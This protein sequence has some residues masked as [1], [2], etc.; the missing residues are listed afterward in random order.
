MKFY[1]YTVLGFEL[2]FSIFVPAWAQPTLKEFEP[3]EYITEQGWGYLSIS[4]KNGNGQDF[5]L[6]A[7]GANAHSC[8]LEGVIRD[9]KAVFSNDSC[10]ILFTKKNDAIQ[11]AVD[12][13]FFD[14]CRGFCGMRAG[15][16][17]SY[18]KPANGCDSQ[19]LADMQKQVMQ[20]REQSDFTHAEQV[21]S[22]VLKNCQKTLSQYRND[23]IHLQ[24]AEIQFLQGKKQACLK[25]LQP[26]IEDSQKPD[27][28]IC[29]DDDKGFM[30]PPSD[31]I[32]A[33]DVIKDVRKQLQRCESLPDE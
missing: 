1:I 20:M 30:L 33:L 4:K 15:F 12:D 18:Y 28:K 26:W 13:G 5:E 24:L 32:N 9:G 22:F 29:K 11:V 25:T 2:L 14:G 17:G 27:E 23:D 10:Q 31:C 19:S 21:L 7:L 16:E 8:S 3:G 6:F